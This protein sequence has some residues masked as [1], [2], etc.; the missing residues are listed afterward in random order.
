VRSYTIRYRTA[1]ST[2]LPRG[3]LGQLGLT[4]SDRR[5]IGFVRGLRWFTSAP[6]WARQTQ[7]SLARVEHGGDGVPIHKFAIEQASHTIAS[8]DLGVQRCP[9]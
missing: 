1:E 8:L 4:K 6:R 3:I 7:Y 9:W 5:G 2:C